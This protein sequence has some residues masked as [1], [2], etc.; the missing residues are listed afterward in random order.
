MPATPN[1]PRRPRLA[2]GSSAGA[3]LVAPTGGAAAGTP[4][5]GLSLGRSLT[6]FRPP[7]AGAAALHPVL[8]AQLLL[9]A[10]R[11]RRGPTRR[12]GPC[13]SGSD[14]GIAPGATTGTS[15]R[16][17]RAS[18]ILRPLAPSGSCHDLLAQLEDRVDQ[19]LRPR[20]AAGQVHVDRHDVVDALHDRVV[21]EHAARLTRRRPSR[22]PTWARPSG[23]RSGAAPG[24]S[25]GSPG[26]RRSSGRPGGARRGRPPCPS[27][28][29]RSA[30]RAGG[31]HLDRA[32]GQAER[33]RARS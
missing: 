6:S 16:A 3:P 22:A 23:R 21:V 9:A 20:R 24:P 30:G 32:A 25:S 13:R 26:R 19:H 4:P 18:S 14:D 12:A 27:G 31:H 17:L 28:P 5:P 8:D 11:D 10:F 1:M 7:P 15:P 29:G 33:G 2:G